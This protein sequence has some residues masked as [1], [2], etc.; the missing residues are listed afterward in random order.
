MTKSGID[1]HHW[2]PLTMGKDY[3]EVYLE[4]SQG[5][6]IHLEDSKVEEILSG[7]DQG[8]GLRHIKQHE[9][10]YS[11]LGEWNPEAAAQLYTRTLGIPPQRSPQKEWKL[12]RVLHPVIQKPEEISLDRKIEILKKADQ[13]VRE[14]FPHIRQVSLT[15]GERRKRFILINSL[16]HFREEARTTVLFTAHVTTEKDGI[17]QTGYEVVGGL[18]G[19]E[20]LE[21]TDPI[22]LARKAARQA[23]AKL[24]APAAR[25]GEMP[26]IIASEAGGTLIHEAIGHSLE[27]DLVQEGTS[28][29]YQGKIGQTVAPEFLTI[30]DDPTIPFY[31][32]SFAYDDEGS[33]ARLTVLVENGV[34][35]DYLYDYTTAQ[36]DGVSSNAHGRRESYHH[37]PIPRMSN[38]YIAPGKDDPREILASLEKGLLVTKMGGGQ[39]NTATGEFVFEVDEGFWVEGGEIKHQ[40]RD[41]SLLGVGPEI[42]KSIDRLGWD[43]GWAIGTCG[44][45]GQ[46]V[47]VSDGL[48]TLR[49][50]K[51]LV[52]GKHD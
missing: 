51:I 39:V 32:G 23:V 2:A 41:A 17:L 19:F 16:G 13:E 24:S 1:I 33:E 44:K 7:R 52:G 8:V 50:P 6:T 46:G 21:D 27:A 38:L 12:S 49:I 42:L 43:M 10:F 48:P 11:S 28:P 22:Q 45:E 26:A 36:K 4:E 35:K 25:A 30:I 29:V 9:T 34:L 31:R 14:G 40:V 18:K 47:P 20:I 3:G 37:K 15:Y 5:T